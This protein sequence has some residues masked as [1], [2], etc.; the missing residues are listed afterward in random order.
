M[1]TNDQQGYRAEWKADSERTALSFLSA[2]AG[3]VDWWGGQ[4][5]WSHP[6]ASS[7]DSDLGIPG[8]CIKEPDN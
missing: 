3:L 7:S 8:L 2:I 6:S 5:P 1:G 4:G